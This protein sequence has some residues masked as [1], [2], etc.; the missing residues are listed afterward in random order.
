MQELLEQIDKHF[1]NVTDPRADRGHNHDLLEM[2][3]LTLTATLCGANSWADVERFGLRRQDWLEQF[4]ELKNGIP[5]HDT[6]GR[7]FARLDSAEF[8]AA[9]YDWVETFAGD[10]RGQGL[11]IDGKTLRGSF[12]H[13]RQTSALQLVTAFATSSR[14][15][16]RQLAVAEGSNE[17]GAVPVLLSLTHSK[18]GGF[19]VR[20]NSHPRTMSRESYG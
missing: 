7:V 15:V 20:L 4:L 9:L 18:W 10:L 2:I 12:D 6:L 13:A 14:L 11:A 16:L 1:E 19:H 3:F 8:I 17:I 5:S